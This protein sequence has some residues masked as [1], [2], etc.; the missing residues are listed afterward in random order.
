MKV[1]TWPALVAG[2][3]VVAS[4]GGS[5]EPATSG[6]PGN[7]TTSSAPPTTVATT[8]TTSLEPGTTTTA[9]TTPSTTSTTTS[10]T[11]TTTEPPG[12]GTTEPIITIPVGTDGIEY[13][14]SGDEQEIQGP[15]LLAI[16]PGGTVHIVDPVGL[17]VLSFAADSQSTIDIGQ[18]DILSVTA[19]AADANE[20]LIVEVFFAPERHRV[21]RV[22]Y[23]GSIT[24]TIDLPVGFRLEDG[25]SGVRG[26]SD[27][28]II[29]EYGG[30]ESFGVWSPTE[31]SFER[32]AALTGGPVTVTPRPPDLEIDGSV[33]TADLTLSLG[34]TRYLGTAADGTHVIVR[35]DVL[36]TNPAFDVL[37]TVE[38]YLPDG[39][40]LGSARVP[41]LAEQFISQVPGI[42]M[43]PD[44]RVVALVA[45]ADEVQVL[46]LARRPDRIVK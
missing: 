34:G 31:Q 36:A 46:E 39:A 32:V 1:R 3:L 44:G 8:T 41:S 7:A 42:A 4:C 43:Y 6:A 22:G 33:I 11:T 27:G 29:L 15:S 14:G 17:R 23:D 2:L 21:H 16:D 25:L 45:F 24:E 19:I 12:G 28:Q 9:P 38:W 10:A 26:G 35:E 37:T 13:R 20:L 18:L 40:L 5:T 30:S